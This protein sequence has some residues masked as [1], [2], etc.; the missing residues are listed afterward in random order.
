VAAIAVTVAILL[1]SPATAQTRG[2]VTREHVSCWPLLEAPPPA[3]GDTQRAQEWVTSAL[4]F[5]SRFFSVV[6]DLPRERAE[7]LARH[8]D[9]MHGAYR[10]AL[11]RFRERGGTRRELWLVDRTEDYVRVIAREFDA[12]VR[13]I[14]GMSLI[15]GG[16]VA[17]VACLEMA[18]P[19]AA[20]ARRGA[21]G[22]RAA[23]TEAPGAAP[24]VD[25]ETALRRLLQHEGFHQA[26]VTLFPNIPGWAAEGLAEVFARAV[27]VG[28]AAILGDVPADRLAR[29]QAAS[30]TR[31]I[32]RLAAFMNADADGEDDP[33]GLRP[34]ETAGWNTDPARP[35]ADLRYDQAWATVHL[36]L[37]GENGRYREAFSQYLTLLSRGTSGQSA[38]TVAFSGA[39]PTSLE[40]ALIASIDNGRAT[41]LAGDVT[42]LT[43]LAEGM[44]AILAAA[45]DPVVPDTLDGLRERLT[46]MSFTGSPAAGNATGGDAIFGAGPE[47]RFALV[48]CGR[49]LPPCIA[50]TGGG[51]VQLGVKWQRAGREGVRWSFVWQ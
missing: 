46:A 15:D 13:R 49:R 10:T 22:A 39:S 4:R 44:M 17:L 36:L 9:I 29:L 37:W 7:A 45:D 47:P 31:Q 8:M 34:R 20:S 2:G 42:R 33:R 11:G 50:V 18:R 27:V 41:D 43:Y 40:P 28:D 38:W 23:G 51:V 14:P 24:P 21:P 32:E 19:P 25:P 30:R 48:E 6:T 35:Y 16:T 1:A 12:D 3:P 5:D 26:Q